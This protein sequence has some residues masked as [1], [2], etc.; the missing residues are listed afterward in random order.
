ME[1]KDELKRQLQQLNQMYQQLDWIYH[2]MALRCGLAD[3]AYWTLY[4]LCDADRPLTQQDLCQSW[5]YSKQTIHSAVSSLQKQ[6]YVTLRPLEGRKRKAVELT[7]EGRR[8]CQST[9]AL[10]FE[11]ER[12]AFA[13]LTPAERTQ[14]L[15]IYEKH[16]GFLKQETQTTD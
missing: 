15:D 3:A 12:R 1:S 8:F 6:G 5:S 7:E 14:L 13:R 11:A 4:A 16:L 2:T 10:L 9:V